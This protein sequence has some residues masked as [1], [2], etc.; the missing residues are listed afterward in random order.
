MSPLSIWLTCVGLAILVYG[1][2]VV[3]IRRLARRRGWRYPPDF[4]RE[5]GTL[6]IGTT[7]VV[8]FVL[9]L[10]EYLAGVG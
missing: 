4:F 1:V 7:A 6:V 8:T 5:F 9:L 2:C 10:L 3:V